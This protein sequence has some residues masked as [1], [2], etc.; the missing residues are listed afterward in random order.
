MVQRWLSRA[1]WRA[2]YLNDPVATRTHL[3][4]AETD[5]TA[6]NVLGMPF[7]GV[8]VGSFQMGSND[9]DKDEKPVHTVRIT[10]PFWT[11]KYEVTQEEYEKL[12]GKNPSRL[13]G[14]GNP[15]EYVSWNGAVAFCKK[16][17][18]RERSAGRLP[19]GY[20]YRLPTEAEWEY[21]ARGGAKG[22]EFTYS[23]S[24]DLDDVGWH[25]G[26]SGKKAHPVGAKRSNELGIHDMSGNVWEWHLDW[27]GKDTYSGGMRTDPRGPQSGLDRV[28]RGGSWFLGASFCR[29]AF[30]DGAVPSGS[31]RNLGFRVALGPSSNRWTD[32]PR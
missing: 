5:P 1:A 21:V 15:V 29:V 22:R 19:A 23:G 6:G 14:A 31:Y 17:T 8:P 26:N 24:N 16:L 4:R 12:A 7:V 2:R 27:Y 9:G 11:G 20:E 10:K 13:K 30:R 18:E 25:S 32:V 3:A 28:Y